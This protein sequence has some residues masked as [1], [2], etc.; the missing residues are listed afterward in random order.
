MKPWAA[1]DC[2]LVLYVALQSFDSRG[3]P[4]TDMVSG[5]QLQLVVYL[6]FLMSGFA[7]A[8]YMIDAPQALVRAHGTQTL[9]GIGAPHDVIANPV[10]PLWANF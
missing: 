9:A 1:R 5:S 8:S 10:L 2:E 6:L 3:I 4:F 7:V